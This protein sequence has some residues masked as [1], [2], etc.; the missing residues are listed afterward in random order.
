MIPSSLQWRIVSIERT[1]DDLPMFAAQWN[2]MDYSCRAD[3]RLRWYNVMDQVRELQRNGCMASRGHPWPDWWV[4]LQL[5]I[6]EAEPLL[7][8]MEL[9][10]PEFAPLVRVRVPV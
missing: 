3:V 1:L 8:A 7:H 10:V 9:P 5:R 2:T 4:M 6:E